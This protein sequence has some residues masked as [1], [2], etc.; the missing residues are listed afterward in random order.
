L[1]SGTPQGSFDLYYDG[2]IA[3]RTRVNGIE[4]VD[5]EGDDP[6]LMWYGDSNDRK[7]YMAWVNG[8]FNFYGGAVGS[9]KKMMGGT[10]TGSL[11]LYYNG[12]RCLR[13]TQYGATLYNTNVPSLGLYSTTQA[14]VIGW[15]W[16]D[17]SPA[18]TVVQHDQNSSYIELQCKASTNTRSLLWNPGNTGLY[19]DLDDQYD[20]GISGNRWDDIWATN[21]VINTSDERKKTTISGSDLGLDFIN[22]LNPVSYKLKDYDWQ[23]EITTH[24]GTFTT[25]SGTK[26]HHRRHYG[27]IAQDVE[28]TLSGIGKD[29]E[30]FAGFIRDEETD[31]YGIRYNEFI[32]PMIKAIQEL[33]AIND[34]QAATISGLE[35]RIEA[36]EGA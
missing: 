1:A 5:P 17:D 20:C 29:T 14:A 19:P 3:L 28:A 23:H 13:S 31:F 4:V 22:E 27:L 18:K 9:E 25:D 8:A 6:Y 16:A 21:N 26:T 10:P 32:A 2:G 12:T 15:C 36:L 30:D 11:D 34:A 7:G 24:S 35:A 33:K